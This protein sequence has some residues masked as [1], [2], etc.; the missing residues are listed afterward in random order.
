M[1][2]LDLERTEAPEIWMQQIAD[3]GWAAGPRL[4][5]LLAEGRF[6][7]LCGETAR[8]LLLTPPTTSDREPLGHL[9]LASPGQDPC[10]LAHQLTVTSPR[11]LS[12]WP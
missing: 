5:A 2:I 9:G 8:V 10:W 6:H 1:E 4:C 12:G 3:C 7:S 11:T